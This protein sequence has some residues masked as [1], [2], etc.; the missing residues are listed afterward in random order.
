MRSYF[1]DVLIKVLIFLSIE[2]NAVFE[3]NTA[4]KTIYMY[5]CTHYAAPYA[6]AAKNYK[7][8]CRRETARRY[9]LFGKLDDGLRR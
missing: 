3:Y 6:E 7:L 9:L 2:Y 8:S 5:A 1:I 4:R